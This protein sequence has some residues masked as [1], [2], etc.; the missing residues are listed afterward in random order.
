MNLIRSDVND[1][2]GAGSYLCCPVLPA[3]SFCQTAHNFNGCCWMK[4]DFPKY[5]ANHLD[6]F[7]SA[8]QNKTILFVTRLLFR[9]DFPTFY[10]IYFFEKSK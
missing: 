7:F 4:A 5:P 9:N 1:D 6:H 3:N 10:F 2:E 8:Q